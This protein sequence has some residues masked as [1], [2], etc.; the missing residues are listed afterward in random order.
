MEDQLKIH[1]T[2]NV[3]IQY[4]I[5]SIGDRL[6]AYLIDMLLVVVYALFI[7][8]VIAPLELLPDGA[9]MFIYVLPIFLYDLL[10]EIFMNGQTPGKRVRDIKVALLDGTQPT[11]GAYLLRWLLRPIDFWLTYGSAALI[12]IL[13]RGTGQRLGDIA[14]G[15]SVIKLKQRVSLADT[16]LTVVEDDYRVVFHQVAQLSDGDIEIVKEVLKNITQMS[17][18]KLRRTLIQRTR[19]SLENKMGI[20]AG[21]AAELFLE[22]VLKDYSYVRGRV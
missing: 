19:R 9:Y 14:A 5:A 7:I 1:T 3:A 18:F 2:Q 15:T 20:E 13:W 12:T 22:T 6:L 16:I 11:L 4:E 17:D 10:F 8:F 21:M